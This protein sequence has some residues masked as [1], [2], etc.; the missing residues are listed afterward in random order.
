MSIG[1]IWP[2]LFLWHTKNKTE[3][4]CS[5]AEGG[6]AQTIGVSL[7]IGICSLIIGICSLIATFPVLA[8]C[9]YAPFPSLSS[10][11]S[12]TNRRISNQLWVLD[13]TSAGAPI[14]ETKQPPFSH[15][16]ANRP[17]II[18][19]T[20]EPTL[21]SNLVTISHPP[22]HPFDPVLRAVI[23]EIANANA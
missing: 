10:P 12:P 20:E 13:V 1:T 15:P 6:E 18:E 5:W 21:R 16:R 9:K 3:W 22:E 19:P 23:T 7:M 2:I 8:A 4:L 14:N 11:D 17:T